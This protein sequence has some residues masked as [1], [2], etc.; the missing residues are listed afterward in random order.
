VVKEFLDFLAEQ[1]SDRSEDVLPKGSILWRAQKGHDTV[2]Q[3]DE[4]KTLVDEV[5]VPHGKLCMTPDSAKVG[6]GRA[7]PK[8]IA[9]LYLATNPMIAIHEVRPWVGAVVSVAA[10]EV[11]HDLKI[12]DFSEH[13]G[14]PPRGPS[15]KE[16]INDLLR[17][18]VRP[19]PT[20][21][22]IKEALL[23]DVDNAFSRP[24]SLDDEEIEYLPTQII[25]ELVRREGYDGVAYKSVF[26]GGQK[27]AY[28]LA[29]FEPENANYVNSCLCSVTGVQV[30]VDGPYD[31][32]WR[33]ECPKGFPEAFKRTDDGGV[34]G[35]P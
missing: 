23:H 5:L 10:F 25:A 12:V 14:N 1:F 7:N 17:G 32:S 16:Q 30:D 35:S 6:S 15:L 13:S 24:V 18:E 11:S 20:A 19:P 27:E 34:A 22:E 3:Y 4:K 9:Y 28:N 26:S 2:P 29:L 21:E 31:Y 33:S 8:G